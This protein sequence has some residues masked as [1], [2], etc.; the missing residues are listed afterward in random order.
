MHRNTFP[1]IA[2]H[3][4]RALIAAGLALPMAAVASP[5]GDAL[6]RLQSDDWITRDTSLA[7]LGISEPVV[8]SNSDAHQDFYLPVPR[9]VPIADATLN[10]D[11]RYTKDEPGR[12]NAVLWADGVPL[13]AQN[14]ADGNGPV[15]R[16]LP[17]E[18]RLRSTGFLRLGVDWQ[19]E[20]ALRRCESNRATANALTISPQTRLSYRYD[21]SAIGNLDDA[22]ST[23]PGKPV[24]LV[25][26]TKLDQQAYDSA[27][28]MGVAMQRAGKRVD[29]KAFPAVGDEIDTRALQVP[30]GLA[31]APVFAAVAGKERHKL[32][33]AAEIGALL[34]L[35]APAVTGDV[36]IA[37]PALR[38]KLNAALDALQTELASDP[39]AA[40]A[41]KSWRQ[42]RAPLAGADMAAKEVR[43]APMGRLSVIAVAPDAGAQAAGVF[44]AAWRRILVSRQVQVQTA[45]PPQSFQGDGVRLSALGGAPDSFDVVA[46]GD[47]NVNFPLASVSSDGRMPDELV[48]D[49]AAAPG[50][51]STRPVASVFWNGILLG[52]KQLDADG[53]PERLT[54]RVP[55]YALGVN[56]AVRVSVQRQPVSV[57]CNEIPQGYPVSVLPTSHV[58]PGQ[59]QPDGTFTGLLPLLAGNPQ[60]LVPDSYLANAPTSLK[61]LIGIATASGVSATRAELAVSPAGQAAKPARTF[62]AMELPLEGAKPKVRVSDQKQLQVAGRS[63][64]WLDISGLS[65]L[66]TAEVVSS[67]GQDGVLWHA[68]GPQSGKLDTPFVLNRGDIAVIAANGPVAWIDST[69]PDA[70]KPPGAGES[71]FFEWRRYIS[72]SVP[73]L[74]FGLLVLVLVLILALRVTRRKNK[75]NG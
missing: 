70:S 46:R 36:V 33:S 54:A 73:A 61:Q 35:G 16:N 52:A 3:L 50:A 62:L 41:F 4:R 22:W 37:S 34:V 42:A 5:A 24:L 20:I 7:D 31:Q 9:G 49:L 68:L 27:W 71:A 11:A 13:A 59:P 15:L 26:D 30:A 23:L 51:S 74:S 65:G 17:L 40:D 14:I 18:Q 38:A 47:W 69:N 10:F 19:S 67:G 53:R 45:T 25:S 48:I 29:V 28:R 6:R 75:G 2:S 8:L 64:T 58:K 12:T 57:D 1:P 55:G 56:N 39:D 60:V 21:A 43:L 63:A 66:S 44:N 72:W 32:A